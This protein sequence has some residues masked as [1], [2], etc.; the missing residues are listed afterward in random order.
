MNLNI[1]KVD[2]D[3]YASYAEK[4]IGFGVGFLM[5]AFTDNNT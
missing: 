1:D 2:W 5:G 3:K 4:A